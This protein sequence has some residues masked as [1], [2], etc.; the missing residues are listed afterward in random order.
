M[1][2]KPLSM[3]AWSGW[4]PAKARPEELRFDLLDGNGRSIGKL[5][6][7]KFE[8]RLRSL[9]FNTSTPWGDGRVESTKDGPRVLLND[10]ELVLMKMYVLK[11]KTDFVFPNGTVM[12]FG[13]MKGK[14]NDIAYSGTDGSVGFFE[15][16]GTLPE[17]AGNRPIPMTREEIKALPKEDRPRTVETDN[18]I[19][20]RIDVGGTLP[21]KEEDLVRA[22]CILA[23]FGRLMDEMTSA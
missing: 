5:V 11:G 1:K 9:L 7:T 10:R 6:C 21:V 2:R 12:E 3:W 8:M 20:Y 18:Y 22:L 17:G 16:A 23:C 19:E 15:E 13:R 14:R 4:N